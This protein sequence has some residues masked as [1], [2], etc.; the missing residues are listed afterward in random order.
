MIDCIIFSKNR[1]CQL[2]FLLRS[3]KLHVDLSDFIV[4]I[5]YTYSNND[6]ENGYKN[7]IKNTSDF[8]WIL[9]KDKNFKEALIENIKEDYIMFLVDDICFLDSF[10]TKLLEFQELTKNNDILT[11]SLR[12]SPHINFC[13]AAN[14]ITIVP[15][16]RNGI[17]DWRQGSGD[18]GYPNSVDGNIFRKQDIFNGLSLID[19]NEP[20]SFESR[21]GRIIRKDTK[22][23]MSCFSKQKLVNFPLNTVYTE[24][25]NRCQNIS[26]ADLNSK[27]LSGGRISFET[28]N[29]IANNMCHVEIKNLIFEKIP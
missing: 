11:L 2:E 3:L 4:K 19:F 24:N 29:G 10:S 22:Y 27:Y 17:W 16:M 28:L 5:I 6:F 23:L 1:A 26:M 15:N 8:N 7:L 14:H 20:G 9:Q 25:A 12:L 13:Y 21:L 18:W